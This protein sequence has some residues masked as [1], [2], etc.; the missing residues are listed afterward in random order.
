MQ[1]VGDEVER[2]GLRSIWAESLGNAASGYSVHI[3]SMPLLCMRS[4][5]PQI[6]KSPPSGSP[7]PEWADDSHQIRG[8]S[9]KRRRSAVSCRSVY[10]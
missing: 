4:D 6:A 5:L 2:V 9:D 1:D 10:L 7:D 8:L 3:Q